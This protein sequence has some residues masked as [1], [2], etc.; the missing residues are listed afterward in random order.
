MEHFENVDAYLDACQQWPDEI[1]ALRPILQATD[2][3]EGIKWGKPCYHLDGANVVLVQEFSDHVALMFFKGVL[4]DDP[5]GML[6]RQG[7]NT[8]A[9]R[10]MCFTSVADVEGF[11]DVVADYVEQA[12]EVERE[13]VELP[14]APAPEQAVEL[15][16]RLE[17]DPELRRAFEALTPGRQREYHLF[18]RGA[19]QESTRRARVEKHVERILAGRGMRER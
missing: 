9:A 17:A 6:Q 18:V 1:R 3:D 11:A 2:L 19:K 10:R 13:G 16:E 14:P 5:A 8:H 4:L 12:I 15:Q 7:P